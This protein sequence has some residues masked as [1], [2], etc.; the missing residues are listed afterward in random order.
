V[1]ARQ[2][3]LDKFVTERISIDAVEAA[4]HTLHTGGVLRS[5]VVLDRSVL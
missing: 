1:A 2:V 5:V 3:P 4:L